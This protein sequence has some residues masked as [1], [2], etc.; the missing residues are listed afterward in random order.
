MLTG[1]YEKSN[2][3]ML[4]VGNLIG[5]KDIEAKLR[6]NRVVAR[7]MA[8]LAMTGGGKTVAA[9]RILKELIEIGYPILILDPHGD[10]LSFWQNRDKFENTKIRLFYPNIPISEDTKDLVYKMIGNMTSGLSDPQKGCF[11]NTTFEC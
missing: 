11:G 4:T 7:H 10:Y 1:D 6:T 9:R 3:S 2:E 5:R 8:I